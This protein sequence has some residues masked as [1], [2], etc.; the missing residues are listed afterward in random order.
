MT[1]QAGGQRTIPESGML[2]VDKPRGVT[3]HDVVAASRRLLHTKKVGH[4]G[5]LDPMA[6]GVLVLGFGDATRLLNHIVEHDKTYEATIRLGQATTTDDA[7]GEFIDVPDVA[8]SADA[9]A[10]VADAAAAAIAEFRS[11]WRELSAQPTEGGPVAAATLRQ[12]I[13]Q[14][15]AARFTG[16][17]DQIPN[18][19]SAIKINGQR[20]YDLARDGRD[21]EL[22][23]RRITV[24]E[25]TVLDLRVGFV[26]DTHPGEPLTDPAAAATSAATTTASLRPVIDLDVRVSCSA[27]TYIRALGRDLGATLGTGGYLTRL[28]RT[29]IGRFHVTDPNV[30]VA[31]AEPHTFTDRNGVEQTRNRAVFDLKPT[32]DGAADDSSAADAALSTRI[33]PMLAAAEAAMPTLAITEQDA[34]NLRY[35]RRIP[36]DIRGTAAAYLPDTGEVVA[37]VERAKRGAA[38]PVTV[39]RANG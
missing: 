23:A 31:H 22:K 29:R 39:F 5:T 9:I 16:D 10:D 24:S 21:V 26:G 13:A 18:T 11:R 25:F 34:D 12:L 27:G 6:T 14:V 36:Y 28:R 38:K 4:A 17:I 35:G 1:A 32:T 33:I 30:V 20:A 37:L 3:S 7:D 15:I 2:I 8:D 19:Y